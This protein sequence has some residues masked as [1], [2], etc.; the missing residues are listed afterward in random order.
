VLPTSVYFYGLPVRE[1]ILV[2]LEPGKTL[3]I[4]AL[5]VGETDSQG[6]VR[7][8]FELNGQPRTVKV[9]DRAH[10]AHG[11]SA[12]RKAEDG[13]A[14]HV[15]APMPGAIATLAVK[16]GQTVSPGDVLLSIEAMKMETTLH[17]ERAGTIAEVLVS[18]G[19]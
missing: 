16:P 7:V 11:A 18:P 3:V 10:G 13:N 5:A 15:A 4:R 9:P 14:N 2:D 8:F 17:A 6:Q 1:E 12:K 19:M